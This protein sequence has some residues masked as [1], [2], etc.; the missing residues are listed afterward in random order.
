MTTRQDNASS[1]IEER[2]QYQADS[3]RS[4]QLLA[5]PVAQFEKW[6]GDAR[7]AKL[8]DATAMA[9]STVDQQ[10]QPHCR[11]VLLKQFDDDGFAWFTDRSSAKGENLAG[12]DKACLLFFWRELERQVRIE[13]IVRQLSDQESDQYFYSRPPG[14][15]FSAA[16]SM[17]SSVVAN[18]AELEANVEKLNQ[19]HPDGNVP[20]PSRWGG[21]SLQPIYFEFWQGRDDRLHDRF[22]YRAENDSWIIERLSP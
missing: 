7:A 19:Q 18:R 2:R 22:G 21:Y 8:I 11:M 9:L 1:L 6:L 15:R 3:L 13:G 12:N 14:S 5:S 4:D 17:Q 10:H 20:R 16:S